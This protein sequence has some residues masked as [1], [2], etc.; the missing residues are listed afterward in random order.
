LPDF[1]KQFTLTTDASN[2]AIGAV[3]SQNLDDKDL[4]IAYASRT[5]NKHEEQLSTIEKELLAIIWSCKH[6]RLYIYGQKISNTNRSQTIT[7]PP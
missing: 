6:F 3:L 4:P 5:L 2:Y 7:I 1:N